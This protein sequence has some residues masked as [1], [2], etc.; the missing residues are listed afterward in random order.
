MNPP[1][2]EVENRNR[3]RVIR[4]YLSDLGLV[5]SNIRWSRNYK[6]DHEAILKKYSDLFPLYYMACIVQSKMV[7]VNE[8]SIGYHHS[9][10]H[11]SPIMLKKVKKL[12]QKRK[13]LVDY[14]C[15]EQT[16]KSEILHQ[17]IDNNVVTIRLRLVF[18][19]PVNDLMVRAEV[20]MN[21]DHW[22]CSGDSQWELMEYTISD[23]QPK[24]ENLCILS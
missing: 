15:P 23:R 1:D 19:T 2:R 5:K 20:D 10:N 9:A 14:L 7:L 6:L 16:K 4:T 22:R 12:I 8:D 21:F 13:D 17:S 11:N 3:I 24:K 18:S